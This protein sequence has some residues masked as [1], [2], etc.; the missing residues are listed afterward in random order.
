MWKPIPHTFLLSLVVT[1]FMGGVSSNAA[2]GVLDDFEKDATQG[3]GATPKKSTPPASTS[4]KSPPADTADDNK[5][6]YVYECTPKSPTLG[7]EGYTDYLFGSMINDF[8]RWMFSPLIEIGERSFQFA[9]GMM[10]R[11]DIPLREEGDVLVPYAQFSLARLYIAQGLGASDVRTSA[12]VGPFAV[13]FRHNNY[14]E[15]GV[16]H[17]LTLRSWQLMYRGIVNENL[18]LGFAFGGSD[19][20]GNRT[21]KGVNF[22]I[23]FEY[24]INRIASLGG[25]VGAHTFNATTVGD[26]R[27]ELRYG[28]RYASMIVGY[29]WLDAP[30]V[31]LRGPLIGLS[32]YY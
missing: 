12:G 27:I 5:C 10:S 32:L 30:L 8:M 20:V 28:A 21:T 19:L 2:G 22:F 23:P 31:K 24:R 26:S 7:T 17:N 13:G 25:E 4:T 18:A 1:V 6:T 29:R 15:D 14:V 11:T 9:T 3:E 16:I